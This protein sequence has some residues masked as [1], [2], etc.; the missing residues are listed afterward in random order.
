MRIARVLIRNFRNFAHLEIEAFPGNAV[1]VGENGIG[2]SNFLYGLRLVLDPDLP[3]SARRLRKEDICE[4]GDGTVADGVEVRIEIDITDF[5]DDQDTQGALDGCIVNTAPLTARITYLWRPKDLA[6]GPRLS[7]KDYDFDI[8]GGPNDEGN[9]KH[10]RHGVSVTVLPP[11]RDAIGELS[12]Y[13][14][15][16][17]HDLLEA[18]PPDDH[19]LDAAAGSIKKAMNVLAEDG[20]ITSVAEGLATRV[21]NMAGP[22]LG[23]S[24]TLGFASSDPAR[25]LKSIRLFVDANRSRGVGETST[26]NANVLYLGLLLQRLE[27]RRGQKADLLLHAIL[28]VEEPEAHIHPVLQRQLFRYLLS[29]ETALVVTTHSPH[30]AAVTKL[31]SLVLLRTAPGGGTTAATTT[32]MQITKGERADLERYLTVSRAELL[33]CQAAIL[34]EGPSEVYLLPALA[35]IFGFDLDAHG[36]IVANIDGVNFSPYRRLLGPDALNIPHVIITDGDPYGKDSYVFGG[37]ARA[38]TLLP[39]KAQQEELSAIVQG[40]IK[41]G[42][43]ADPTGARRDVTRADIFV[44]QQ[45][46]EVDIAPLLYEQ[47]CDAHQEL[48]ESSSLVAKFDQAVKAIDAGIGGPD[49]RKE[50]LRRINYVSKGRFAQ[51][52]ADHVEH[53]TD[54]AEAVLAD[55]SSKLDSNTDPD[56]SAPAWM[57]HGTYGYLLAALDRISWGIRGHGLLLPEQATHEQAG[58]QV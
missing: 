58:E 18:S 47:M 4:H 11:L 55:I 8:V 37:L 48:E 53:A 3:D 1:L 46:L 44:G 33:F 51:R 2:K 41:D 20:K 22:Q 36:V 34:V 29:M 40:L 35:R 30:I 6:E 9:A 7:I 12:R 15:S 23:I 19:A 45:T 39:S 38:A 49:D 25:L 56:Q 31:D 28:G 24:P 17:L 21:A 54:I 26:G 14:G 52:L 43:A 57:D 42:E 27:S 5:E 50:L 10:I 16:P 32:K 13:R